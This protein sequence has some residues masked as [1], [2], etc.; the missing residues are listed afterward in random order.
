[1]KENEVSVTFHADKNLMDEFDKVKD[2]KAETLGLT[3]LTRKQALQLAI[4]ESI[5]RWKK[6]KP[7]E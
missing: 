1:M 5:E 3:D 2:L 6:E 4:K 7:G